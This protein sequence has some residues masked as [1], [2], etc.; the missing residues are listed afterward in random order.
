MTFQAGSRVSVL[1]HATKA[2]DGT[3]IPCIG[4]VV[5]PHRPTDMVRLDGTPV[6]HY[7]DVRIG[8]VVGGYHESSLC[9]AP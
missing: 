2:D 4:I 6:G 1:P 8:D 3:P 7:V 5:N 9:D